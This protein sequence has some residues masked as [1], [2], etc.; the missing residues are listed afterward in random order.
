M[1]QPK[2]KYGRLQDT[3]PVEQLSKVA[4]EFCGTYF[5]LHIPRT[6]GIYSTY[7]V[8]PTIER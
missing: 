5:A 7:G 2:G 6:I 1:M 4:S 3:S 8:P